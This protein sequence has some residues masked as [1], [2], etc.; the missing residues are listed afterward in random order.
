M[1]EAKEKLKQVQELELIA[2]IFNLVKQN[3]LKDAIDESMKLKVMPF[4]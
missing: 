2:K 4:K 3:K 1:K